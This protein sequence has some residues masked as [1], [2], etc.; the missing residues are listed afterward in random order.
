MEQHKKRTKKS[1]LKY[2][3]KY[4]LSVLI[5]FT[6][7]FLNSPKSRVVETGWKDMGFQYPQI[8]GEK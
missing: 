4:N 7:S 5:G 6:K 1:V 3:L 2:K 8:S